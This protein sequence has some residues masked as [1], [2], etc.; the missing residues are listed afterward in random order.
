MVAVVKAVLSFDGQADLLQ[1]LVRIAIF[2]G[3]FG[4]G[5]P[6][7]GIVAEVELFDNR[8]E[9]AALT[10][11]FKADGLTFLGVPQRINEI[12]VGKL[13]DV[14][15][16]LADALLHDF[17]SSLLLLL[18]F[19]VVLLRQVT[20]RFGIGEML[21]FHEEL[22]RVA[23]LATAETFEDVSRWVDAK[24]WRLLIVERTIAPHIR[25]TLLQRD[26]LAYNLLNVSG[27]QDLLHCFLWDGHRCEIIGKTTKLI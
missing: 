11:I 24:R 3:M 25:P 14:E 6:F 18:D 7:G 9:I 23:R 16:L 1:K 20:Q 4:E 10:E 21:V 13:V 12:L 26:E 17:L 27:L 15:H 19:D 2:L 22:G 5:V 8:V